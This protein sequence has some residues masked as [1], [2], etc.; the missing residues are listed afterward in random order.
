MEG[1]HGREY[2]QNKLKE[3]GGGPRSHPGVHPGTG[4]QGAGRMSPPIRT[5]DVSIVLDR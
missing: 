3:R 5:A 4:E 2:L 1:A